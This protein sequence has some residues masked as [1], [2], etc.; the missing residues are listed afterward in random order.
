[1]SAF[2]ACSQFTPCTPTAAGVQAQIRERLAEQ[3]VREVK[4]EPAGTDRFAGTVTEQDGSVLALTVTVKDGVVSFTANATKAELT[5]KSTAPG[6]ADGSTLS[7]SNTV[8]TGSFHY[9]E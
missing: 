7:S 9:V 8:I 4:V 2:A 3:G 5:T 1:M 6:S